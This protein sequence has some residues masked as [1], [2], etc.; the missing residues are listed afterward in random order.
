MD[1]VV[2]LPKCKAYGQFYDAI[3]IVIDRL[4]KKRH[5]IPCLEED[6]RTSAKATA[7]LFLQDV[8]FKYGLPTSMTSD[9]ESQFVLKIWDFLCKLLG[10]KAKLSTAFHPETNG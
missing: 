2:G 10:I 6:E 8:W 1:F 9:H 3:L 4:S 7:D 5:Y